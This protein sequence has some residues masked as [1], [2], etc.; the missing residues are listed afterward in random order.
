VGVEELRQSISA[1]RLLALDTV[2]FSYHLFN[3]PRY[4]PLTR[5]VLEAIESGQVAGLTTTITMAEVLT[6]AAQ[7]EDR[8][9]MQDYELYLTHF[10]NL[11]IVPLDITLARETA[12][13][14]AVSKLRVPDAVQVA[15]ARL[16]GADAI[17]T[18][19]RRW[20]GKVPAP[21][22]VLLGDYLA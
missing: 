15:A 14:R 2:V 19:G 7:A 21:R 1:C 4:A 13:V 9:A 10:P 8:R 17:V 18:N 16:S 11:R 5:V 3:H 20:V 6:V 12:R 22:L